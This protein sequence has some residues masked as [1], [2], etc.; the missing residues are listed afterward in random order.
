M[1]PTLGFEWLK[2]VCFAS[3][4][5][6]GPYLL[7]LSQVLRIASTPFCQFYIT[8]AIPISDDLLILCVIY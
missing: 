4:T 6:L 5:V 3:E 2:F 1:M 7:N 8:T